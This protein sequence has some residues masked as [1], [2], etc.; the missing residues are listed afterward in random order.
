MHKKQ[1]IDVLNE[2]MS[3]EGFWNNTERSTGAVKELKNLKL[4]VEPWELANKKY[5]LTGNQYENKYYNIQFCP[6]IPR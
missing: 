6:R 2:Q 1:K 5:S 4:T 3:V